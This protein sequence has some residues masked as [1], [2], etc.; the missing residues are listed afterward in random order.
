MDEN[1]PEHKSLNFVF[2]ED[3][4]A[5]VNSLILDYYQKFGKKRDLEQYFSLSTAKSDIRDPKSLFWRKMKVQSDSS[6][7]GEGKAESSAELCRISIKCSIPEPSTSQHEDLQSKEDSES[8]PIITEELT[9][10]L[11]GDRGSPIQS[12]NESVKS[13]DNNSQKSTEVQLESSM[14]K[15]FSPTSSINSQRKLEWDSLGDVGY[16]NESEQKLSGSVLST[17]ERLALHQQYSNNDTKHD[18]LLGAPKS[19]STPVEPNSF[20]KEKKGNTK[21]TTKIYKKDV[22]HVEF[23]V[24]YASENTRAISVNLS[25][26]ISFNVDKSGELSVENSKDDVKFSQD[27]VSVETEMTSQIKIDKEIQTTLMRN[28]TPKEISIKSKEMQTDKH[29]CGQKLPIILNLNTIKKRRRRRKFNMYKRNLSKQRPL[30]LCLDKT[31]N[32]ISE[33]DS[34]EYLPGHIYNQNR[35]NKSSVKETNSVGNK[36]SLESSPILTTDSSKTTKNS[37]SKDLEKSINL[38]KQ[39]LKPKYDNMNLKEKLI[40]EVVQRLLKASYSDDD[41]GTVFLSGLHLETEK[42]DLPKGNHTT[43]STSDGT[44]FNNSSKEKRPKKSILRRD[45]FNPNGMASTSQSTPN[46]YTLAQSEN[47]SKNYKTPTSSNTE[48]DFSSKERNSSDTIPKMTSKELYTKYLEAFNREQA[49]KKLLKSKEILF[50]KKLVSS[51]TCIKDVPELDEKSRD[52]LYKLM[53]DLAQNNVDDGSGDAGKSEGRSNFDTD[54]YNHAGKQR[55]HS[56]FTLASDKLNRHSKQ[57]SQNLAQSDIRSISEAGCSKENDTCYVCPKHT[58]KTKSSINDSASQKEGCFVGRK[59][60]IGDCYCRHIDKN[61]LPKTS[62][63]IAEKAQHIQYIC[64]CANEGMDT[65]D[66]PEKL[67]IYKCSQVGQQG[68]SLDV[69]SK[70]SSSVGIQCSNDCLCSQRMKDIKLP[71]KTIT[72]STICVNNE[73]LPAQSSC[74]DVC[75]TRKTSTSSQTQANLDLFLHQEP[76]DKSESSNSSEKTCRQIIVKKD[77]VLNKCRNYKSSAKFSQSTQTK[78]SIEAKISNPT[79]T[80]VRFINDLDL[81]T[82]SD[83]DKDYKTISKTNSKCTYD[84]IKEQ[85]SQTCNDQLI[86]PSVSE[87]QNRNS[88][89]LL[90]EVNN[91]SKEHKMSTSQCPNENKFSIPIRG[92]KMTLIV[93]LDSNAVNSNDSPN[94]DFNKNCLSE[95]QLDPPNKGIECRDTSIGVQCI[96]ADFLKKNNEDLNGNIHHTND[97]NKLL[98]EES[99]IANISNSRNNSKYKTYPIKS[100]TGKKPFVRSNTYANCLESTDTNIY[101]DVKV[102]AGTQKNFQSEALLETKTTINHAKELLNNS[103][104]HQR[105]KTSDQND[106]LTK[107]STESTRDT[108]NDAP[109]DPVLK[110][111]QDITKRYK[112]E[113]MEK[114]KRKKCF[115][116]IITVLN[117]LLDT[118]ESTDTKGCSSS[119]NID[120]TSTSDQLYKKPECIP[121]KTYVDKGIQLPFK[122]DKRHKSCTDSCNPSASEK[123]TTST[124]SGTC[125]ILH[126]IEKECERYHQKRCRPQCDQGKCDKSSSTSVN[127]KNC[128]R[129]HYCSFR[130]KHKPNKTKSCVDRVKKKCVAYNLILQTSDSM[131]SEETAHNVACEPLKNVIVKVPSKHAHLSKAPFREISSKIEKNLRGSSPQFQS[132]IHRSKSLPN[133][134]EKSSEDFCKTM[135][136]C[137]VR[138]YLEMNRPDFIERSTKRQNCLKVI[139]QSRPGQMCEIPGL[140][141]IVVHTPKCSRDACLEPCNIYC[142]GIFISFSYLFTFLFTYFY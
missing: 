81:N 111:I 70:T 21:K 41:S 76:N 133:D 84:N 48:S 31:G 12:E 137:T 2:D 61:N 71:I 105:N 87:D 29:V 85:Q 40:K 102:N 17:L 1:V 74:T 57:V 23:N 56:V 67:L 117:Y 30:N 45:K 92:T 126:N 97:N 123:P 20:Q 82:L 93:S 15:P 104:K 58:I 53:K 51:D 141:M 7:S 26:H 121:T 109:K 52:R 50:K 130:S 65:H 68:V 22:D 77:N 28:K 140:K 134:S 11:H 72:D 54:Q 131:T 24:P 112:K 75:P 69:I 135:Q 13:D 62:D 113:D 89:D 127:C 94:L 124:D 73:L 55:C 125:K 99:C 120:C 128:N 86:L 36:S 14:N 83:S 5:A 119:S 116:D 42:L 142:S 114:G 139:N 129:M 136:M 4:Q 43:T 16:A 118:E 103:D 98:Q 49:H 60:L 138:D 8:P 100:Q 106:N 95:K 88:R 25:K 132:K 78:I 39:T 115:K 80:D 64:L 110:I 63:R 122:K 9:T 34:F 18:N 10:S 37:F 96:S 33:A 47:P 59:D 66:K 46:L 6:D 79:L 19:H 108:D 44:N 32:Q 107:S 27:K 3:S 101:Q 90:Y 35:S 91:S 38:L